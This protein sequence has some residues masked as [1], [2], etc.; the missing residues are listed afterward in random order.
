MTFK[1]LLP[2]NP[3]N[4]SVRCIDASPTDSVPQSGAF[5]AVRR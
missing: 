4:G 3:P 2:L 5:L 1:G